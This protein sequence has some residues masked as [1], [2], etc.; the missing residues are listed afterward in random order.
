[1]GNVVRLHDGLRGLYPHAIVFSAV[2]TRDVVRGLDRI[3]THLDMPA[4][5]RPQPV[6]SI[7]AS[8]EG[9]T[10]WGDAPILSLRLSQLAVVV[11][12]DGAVDVTAVVAGATTRISIPLAVPAEAAHIAD[13]LWVALSGRRAV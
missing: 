4:L 9:I 2:G 12:D 6:L 7:A 10:V 13:R 8:P 3:R 11:V 1:M 5:R